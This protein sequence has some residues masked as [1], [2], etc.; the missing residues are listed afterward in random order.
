[1]AN[2]EEIYEKIRQL[3]SPSVPGFT[4]LPK[5]P[6][7]RKLLQNLYSEKEAIF[8]TS[9]LVKT[10][11][12]V[13]L[14]KAAELAGMSL[15]EA[16]TLWTNML[17]TGKL[18]SDGKENVFISAYLPGVFESYF[19]IVKDDPER[20]K[21]VAIAHRGLIKM[22]FMPDLKFTLKEPAEFN[23]KA[24]WRFV[25]ALEPTIKSIQINE[26]IKSEHQILPFEVL[27]KYLSKYDIFS[28]TPCS[29]RIAAKL[30]GEPCKRT[31]ESFCVQAGSSAEDSIRL[32]TGQKLNFNEVMEVL[33]KASRAGLVH[34]TLNMLKPATFICNC[35]SCCCPSLIA[36]KDMRLKGRASKTN[37]TPVIDND[38]CTLCGTC[39][40]MCPMEA[41]HTK[42]KEEVM[43]INLD[44]CI[45]C[46][47][48]AAN[49]PMDAI[50]L[51]KT[52]DN[53][54]AESLQPVRKR[55]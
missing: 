7:T 51:K 20:M 44:D 34:S 29:C 23:P 52:S 13:P 16:R 37:F 11:D 4:H 15:E 30:A 6:L 19:T 14:G 21:Q 39:A 55:T 18:P 24:E 33:M 27:E 38:V 1:M 3:L 45:G 2:T 12:K 25:P 9:C 36:I 46:G 49:C 48:C 41:I 42:D 43:A 54:P 50:V 47:V 28:V 17:I 5:H 10:W 22:A 26:A 8:L 53:I 35:C 31:D 40:Q 32:G